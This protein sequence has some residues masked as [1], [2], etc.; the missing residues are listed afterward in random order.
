MSTPRAGAANVLTGNTIRLAL[1]GVGTIVIALV[2]GPAHKGALATLASLSAIASTFIGLGTDGALPYYVATRKWSLAEASAVS[3]GWTVF[4]GFIVWW[5]FELLRRTQG[6]TLLKGLGSV[7]LAAR[8]ERGDRPLAAPIPARDTG[9]MAVA[10]GHRGS[11]HIEDPAP[12]QRH[13]NGPRL[14]WWHGGISVA[15]AIVGDGILVPL[16]SAAGAAAL[17]SVSYGVCAAVLVRYFVSTS[18]IRA[19]EIAPG[20]SDAG[21]AVRL[22][23]RTAREFVRRAPEAGGA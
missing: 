16:I 4:A 11:V 20:V 7:E 21:E 5:G 2:I 19:R 3:L 23:L 15:V 13:P 9:A 17:M 6:D 14:S 12:P 1:G 18:G 22:A 10:A 8:R